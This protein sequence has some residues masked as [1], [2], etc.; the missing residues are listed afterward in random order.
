[1]II[2]PTNFRQ[3]Q[4]TINIEMAGA[5]IE[6]MSGRKLTILGG[7]LIVCQVLSFLVGAI[8]AP[9]PNNTDQ[10]LATKCYDREGP[11]NGPGETLNTKWFYP[12]GKGACKT[13]EDIAKTAE[14]VALGADNVVF[15]FRMPLPRDGMELDYSR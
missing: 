6:N 7:I 9:S 1:M 14:D 11:G 13:I 4:D 8:F 5:I 3:T 10:L 2:F 15:S 12:R